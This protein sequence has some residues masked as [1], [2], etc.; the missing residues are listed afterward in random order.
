MEV[1]S[2]SPLDLNTPWVDLLPHSEEAGLESQIF[3]PVGLPNLTQCTGIPHYNTSFDD[4]EDEILA[5]EELCPPP[6]RS[7][8][9][10]SIADWQADSNVDNNYWINIA[11]ELAWPH[12]SG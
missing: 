9:L 6:P 7:N 12:K 4:G 3:T 2:D 1:D 11:E 10:P 8:A 5:T